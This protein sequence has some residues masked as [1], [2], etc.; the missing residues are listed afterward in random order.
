MR[1]DCENEH[2]A[3]VGSPEQLNVTGVVNPGE[4]VSEIVKVAVCP[5]RMVALEGWLDRLKLA[6][7]RL[8]V[9]EETVAK[10]V[11]P[12]YCAISAF[13]PGAR[14]AVRV[15]TPEAFTGELPNEVPLSVNV[16]VPV[17]TPAVELSVA[18]S[19]AGCPG[20]TGL[21]CTARVTVGVALFTTC[22]MLPESPV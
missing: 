20:T 3:S 7:C 10:F 8:V 1:V 12:L 2:D 5:V 18:V 11:S 17:G 15:A 21:G 22:V 16:I 4:G 9:G 13:D 6:S 14:V 19:V